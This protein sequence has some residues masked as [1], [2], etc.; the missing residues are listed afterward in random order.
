MA[1]IKLYTKTPCPYCVN[2]KALLDEL[3][4]EYEAIDITSDHDKLMEIAEKSGQMTLP[5]LVVNDEKWLG[6]FDDI[7]S[8]YN[9]GKL[10]SE[11]NME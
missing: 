10:L 3:N 4:V 11:L 1:N 6:G 8:L 2:A 9:K 7:N 5:Q